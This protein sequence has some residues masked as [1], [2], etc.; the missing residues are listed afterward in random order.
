MQDKE[1][2]YAEIGKKIRFLRRQEDLSQEK[3]AYKVG[4]KRVSIAQIEAGKQTVSVYILYKMAEV[5]GKR[6]SEFL[7][8][9]D[10]FD[11]YSK[12]RVEK[13]GQVLAILNQKQKEVQ[14]E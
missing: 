11:S 14:N 1:T 6:I 2:L 9:Y 12:G 10:V 4:L 7:P 8:E 3:L 13:A 5:L